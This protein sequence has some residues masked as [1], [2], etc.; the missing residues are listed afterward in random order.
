MWEWLGM[1]TDVALTLESTSVLFLALLTFALVRRR[2]TFIN[3][4]WLAISC[5]LFVLFLNL[6]LWRM[7]FENNEFIF[8]LQTILHCIGAAALLEFALLNLR[9]S[10]R[11]FSILPVYVVSAALLALGLWRHWFWLNY[12]LKVSFY[13]AGYHMCYRLVLVVREK[14]QLSPRTIRLLFWISLICPLFVALKFLLPGELPSSPVL[15]GMMVIANFGVAGSLFA[16]DG[17][18]WTWIWSRNRGY[19]TLYRKNPRYTVWPLPVMA[20]IILAG[21][22][23]VN[24]AGLQQEQ[25]QLQQFTLQLKS[26]AINLNSEN[27]RLLADTKNDRSQ[28]LYRLLK[29][30]MTALRRIL[31]HVKTL[32]L[33]KPYGD[34]NRCIL[35]TDFL[36]METRELD[37]AFNLKDKAD[38]RS[39]YQYENS[40]ARPI[41]FGEWGDCQ[42]VMAP[43]KEPHSGSVQAAVGAA[44]GLEWWRQQI[45]QVRL[46]PLLVMFLLLTLLF[47]VMLAQRTFFEST[48]ANL[49]SE[50]RFQSL[51]ANI[52]DAFLYGSLITDQSNQP[53]DFLILEVNNTFTLMAGLKP[54]AVQNL[55]GSEIIPAA[56]TP[57]WLD[58][59]KQAAETGKSIRV[60]T[61]VDF[62]SR[63]CSVAIY[64]PHEPNFACIFEDITERRRTSQEILDTKNEVEKANRQL[65]EVNRELEAAYHQANA[66]AHEAQVANVAKNQFLANM[67]HEIRTP[68]TGIMGMLELLRDT[69]LE[70]QQSYYVKLAHL[71]SEGLLQV[72]NDILDISK[73]EAGKLEIMAIT[74]NLRSSLADSLN[75]LEFRAQQKNLAFQFSFNERIPAEVIGDPGR[76]RQIVINLVNNAIKFTGQ[77]G[78]NIRFELGKTFQDPP[79]FL[80]HG[81]VEDTG[82]GVPPGKEKEIFKP[83]TQADGSF[84]REFGGTGLGLTIT[85]ELAERMGGRVWFKNLAKG[86]CIFH[87][88]IRLGQKEEAVLEKTPTPVPQCLPAAPEAAPGK[89]ILFVEDNAIN[90]I[91]VVELLTKNGFQVVTLENGQEALERLAQEEFHLLL[92]DVQMPVMD[93]LALT[94]EIRRR[95]A[96]NHRHLPIVGLT[97]HS[98]K[99]DQE[100]C[101]LAG[102]DAYFSKPVDGFE[103][104][105]KIKEWLK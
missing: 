7:G 64:S 38:L 30:Q 34:K 94:A 58:W 42:L 9:Q 88:T 83:F 18:V 84:S 4:N 93:G 5:F 52:Q 54:R 15:N 76:L 103:I 51:F 65:E 101:L 62:L 71:S 31:P 3:W 1:Q 80:L 92:T 17:L 21:W 13:A 102:M 8:A 47:E 55:R 99:G 105:N 48:L 29:Q 22:I 100:K 6:E 36:K 46:I 74:F 73:I 91:Y 96:G 79:G 69:P 60:E 49:R 81:S 39:L 56:V 104:V 85:Q 20:V 67:S 87:F 16:L 95:E 44:I 53:A 27:L 33:I 63:W 45:E 90:Q 59:F 43:V 35:D 72:L 57:Q 89:K 2:M 68:L 37:T 24:L 12:I 78:V 82:P 40:F 86:G 14:Y 70:E 75:L 28:P 77:G 10:G 26:L 50:G 23:F 66:L 32:F 19:R 25:R 41:H 11:G 97:A 61:Y 98:M